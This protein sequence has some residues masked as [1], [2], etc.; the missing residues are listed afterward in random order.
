MRAISTVLDVAVFLLLVSAAVATLTLVP[1]DDPEPVVVD[2]RADL[3]A[4]SSADV[5]Y[6]VGTE[7]RTAHGTAASL[8]A[9][10]AVANASIDGRRL[11]SGHGEF[12]EGV[13]VATRR[14]LGADNR[15]Q[16]VVRW[17]PYRG[18][19]VRGTLRVGPDPPP[20]RD[21]TVATLSVP[22]PV[23]QSGDRAAVAAR[24]DGF[25]GV[26]AVA[27]RATVDALLPESSATLPSSRVSPAS[28]AAS[29]RFG[30]LADA[31]GVS[32]EG[33]LSRGNVSGAR[34]RAVEGLT[35]RY[36]ADMRERF[37]TPSAAAR[38]VRVGTVRVVLRRWAR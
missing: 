35:D 16:V 21:V 1:D 30:T 5:E 33:P 24:E 6:T 15:T 4:S 28:V 23:G 26:A 8:L 22:A 18:G 2:E 10:G 12:V 20:G 36:A 7:N 17:V 31:T 3:L 11:S 14:T 9:R 13:A 27:A 34:E 29:E 32:V 38:A 25:R 19:P 37:E